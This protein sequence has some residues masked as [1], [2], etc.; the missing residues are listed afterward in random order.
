MPQMV[1]TGGQSG[2]KRRGLRDAFANAYD[3][4]AAE[5]AEELAPLANLD[6]PSDTDQ[7][8]YAYYKSAP[9]PAF[10]PEGEN[11]RKAGFDAVQFSVY[12]KD[13]GLEVEWRKNDEA[14][15]QIG[16][17]R[18]R[19]AD[20]GKNFAL[21]QH[22]VFFQLLTGATSTS[23]LPYATPTA[24]DGAVLFATTA[25]GAARFGATNGNLLTGTGVAA[26]TTIR[27]DV[28]GALEQFRLFQD[29]QGQ[30]LWPDRILDQGVIILYGAALEEMF[31]EAFLQNPTIHSINTATSNAGVQNIFQA[32]GK[33][34]ELRP[35]QYITDNDYFIFLRGAPYKPIFS[36]LRQPLMEEP[37]DE[38]N[39]VEHARSLQRSMIWHKREGWG[40]FLPYAAIKINN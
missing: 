8:F 28:F 19:I 3:S 15:D 9:H 32:A 12:N 2:T 17:L 39:S 13:W 18:P 29:S 30:Q 4:M 26:S 34:I 40:L 31:T 11:V 1:L 10:W 33:A 16:K 36:Q 5:I 22:R 21:L 20:A 38:G 6:L 14:D 37:F 25:G 24:P 27:A 7:E 35:T 23:L